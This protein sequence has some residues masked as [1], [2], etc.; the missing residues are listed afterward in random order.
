MSIVNPEAE[1]LT[2]KQRV[3]IGVLGVLS[4]LLAALVVFYFNPD[5]ESS[6]ALPGRH[7]SPTVCEDRFG[8]HSGEHQKS[9]QMHLDPGSAVTFPM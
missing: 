6:E 7:P 8:R 2:A 9:D 5:G 1:T 3:V 4:V